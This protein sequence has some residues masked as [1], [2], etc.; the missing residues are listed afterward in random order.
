MRTRARAFVVV[1]FCL[2]F[3]IADVCWASEPV[4]V[5][6]LHGKGSAPG[7]QPVSGLAGQLREAG[8]LVTVPEM[9][10]SRDRHYD[11]AYEECAGEID[12][13]VAELKN[14]GAKRIVIAG[15]SLGANVALFY[16]TRRTADAIVAMA[17]GHTPE[18]PGMRKRF[19][20]ELEKARSMVEKGQGDEVSVFDDVNQGRVSVVKT[21]PR[22]YLGWFAPDGPAVM[23]RNVAALRQG[24]ALLWVVGTKDPLF[25]SGASYAFDKARP[26]PRSKYLV[27][28]ADHF[29]TPLQA[30]TQIIDWIKGL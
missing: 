23:P 19:A 6:L 11:K 26:D 3:V 4:G 12:A 8:F 30:A 27:V 18:R 17:P 7:N 5:V 22:I 2:L 28:D 14:G 13:A 9:P 20:S 29:S 25:K 10:Y 16:A 24:T 21:T 1:A 15:H